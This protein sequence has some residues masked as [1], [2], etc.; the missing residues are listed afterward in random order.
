MQRLYFRGIQSLRIGI[1]YASM[2]KFTVGGALS[3]SYKLY[4]SPE[5][6]IASIVYNKRRNQSQ[7]MRKISIVGAAAGYNFKSSFI[8]YEI[9]GNTNG[10]MPLPVYINQIIEPVWSNL[11]I[12]QGHDFALEEDG[13]DSGHGKAKKQ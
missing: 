5:S 4:V 7:R 9:P 8:F 12:V 2:T 6:N 3:I 1:L 13:R 11:G 10:K